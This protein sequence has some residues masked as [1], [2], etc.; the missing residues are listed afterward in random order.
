MP[1]TVKI[2]LLGLGARGKALLE[3]AIAPVCQE[4]NMELTALYDPYADRREEGARLARQLLGKNPRKCTAP[5]QMLRD[6]E[7][8]AVIIATSWEQHIPL[9]L[10]AMENGKYVG[11]E[12]GGAY[13]LRDCWQLVDTSERTGMP[14][15]LLENCCYGKRELMVLH[16]VRQGLFGS[17]VHCA[18]GYHH[19]LREEII[20]GNINRHYRLRNYLNRNC[21]NYPTHELGPIAK[22]LDINCGNR[23]VSLSSTAS[24][25]RGLHEYALEKCTPED[26]LTKAEFAQGDVV[27]TVLKCA[28]GQTIVLTL[29]TTLPRTY[30]RGF[31]VRGTK[32]FYAEDGDT[33]YLDDQHRGPE[34]EFA[35]QKLWG[36]AKEF[37]TSYQ[38]PLWKNYTPSGGHDGMDYLVIRAFL[39]AVR[40]KQPVPIDVYDTAT[41][42]SI[43][44]LSEQSILTG[45][46][47]VC[48]PDFTRGSWYMRENTFGK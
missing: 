6:P 37:E 34:Y 31:T 8:D 10:E 18:G 44:A 41:L 19:D 30:S 28:K 11:L 39:E 33:V 4:L 32:G 22:V 42:M 40:E 15:M 20:S 36:N 21:E 38:H 16:M 24:C 29:D 12:V 17:V 48:V 2:G 1:K 9:A 26:P 27:T 35:P 43:S 25:A 3:G 45:G 46:S 5:E 23:I 13:E 7:I 14:C 47:V